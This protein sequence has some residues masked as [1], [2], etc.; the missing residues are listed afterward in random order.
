M[1]RRINF[2][3][4]NGDRNKALAS[5]R[6]SLR[7]TLASKQT[8]NLEWLH[9]FETENLIWLPRYG[10]LKLSTL[11]LEERES[12]A[13]FI[14]PPMPDLNKPKWQKQ[15][16]N[17]KRKLKHAIKTEQDAGHR[18]IELLLTWLLEQPK[19]KLIKL[20]LV[21]VEQLEMKRTSQRIMTIKRYIEAHNALVGAPSS[22]NC[23][24]VQEGVLKIP[25]KWN[26][27]TDIISEEEYINI[28]KEFLLHYFPKY[29][30]KAIVCHSDERQLDENT[31]EYS[32]TGAHTHYYLSAMN[33]ETGRYDLNRE[34]IETVDMYMK[35]RGLS[36]T[37]LSENSDISKLTR[38]QTRKF[39]EYFQKMLYEFVN[40]RL[41][42]AKG[43]NAEFAPETIRKSQQRQK[44]NEQ[45]KLPKQLR[46]YN[47]LQLNTE[48]AQVRLKQLEHRLKFLKKVVDATEKSAALQLS[49]VLK[50]VYVRTY[51]MQNRLDKQ[52]A[53][54]LLKVTSVAEEALSIEMKSVLYD[55]AVELEDKDL[56]YQLKPTV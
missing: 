29:R 7:I 26:V 8:K 22:K 54:Y 28:T 24:S 2:T 11:T 20:D 15:R 13:R 41:L 52:A 36:K 49:N 35:Q 51:C 1:H 23:V 5:V 31:G 12:L 9:E 40:E 56:A 25:H 42:K 33:R 3:H 34:Q 6:H 4:R 39:G 55:I 38:E 16:S 32:T 48:K 50:D 47:L 21:R 44:M 53:S 30:I 10:L 19:D 27:T 46:E 14:A 37:L 17:A 43:L 45:A 18:K